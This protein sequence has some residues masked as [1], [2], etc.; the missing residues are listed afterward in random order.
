MQDLVSLIPPTAF[1]QVRVNDKSYWTFTL[2]V[3]II[4]T[5]LRRWPI[6]TFYQDGKAHLRL[7]ESLMRN[8]KGIENIGVW[9]S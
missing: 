4:A 8:A 9:C 1:C 3:H 2:T 5:Y 6:E 7:D